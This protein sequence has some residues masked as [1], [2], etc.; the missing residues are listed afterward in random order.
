MEAEVRKLVCK[1]GSKLCSS[2][3]APTFTI[4]KCIDA[5]SSLT[6]LSPCFTFILYSAVEY[7]IL[8]L[9]I[10]FDTIIKTS[11]CRISREL[12]GGGG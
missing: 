4:K 11:G 9:V 3:P 1:S 12:M 7:C 6:A 2:D 8:I 10:D 5:L